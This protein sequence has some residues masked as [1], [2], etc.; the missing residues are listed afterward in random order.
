MLAIL[1]FNPLGKTLENG[2]HNVTNA[3]GLYITFIGMLAVFIGL[4]II[5]SSVVVFRK[6]TSIRPRDAKI[7][8]KVI[9]E[10]L[11]P[12]FTGE[13]R[14]DEELAA[15]L[16]ALMAY[17]EEYELDPVQMLPLQTMDKSMSPWV[18]VA[19]EQMMRKW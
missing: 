16:A 12:F 2:W 19:R 8:T 4:I 5:W 3:H 9:D 10:S 14:T 7:Q 18:V 13:N 11:S 1:L 17:Y 6:L 15:V